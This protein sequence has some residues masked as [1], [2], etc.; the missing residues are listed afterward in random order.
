M[1][2][3]IAVQAATSHPCR[4]L[5]CQM[6]FYALPNPQQ[7][8][9]LTKLEQV[10]NDTLVEFETRGV[11]SDDLLK[12]KVS[13][14]TDAIYGLQ[15]VAGK[16][17]NLAHYQTVLGNANYTQQ[18]VARYNNVTK[19]DVMRVFKQYIKGKTLTDP[20]LHKTILSLMGINKQTSIHAP[21]S[22]TVV[23]F[24]TNNKDNFIITLDNEIFFID[25]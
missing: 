22:Y 2:S 25:P 12:T 9:S 5:S 4:E 19:A 10:I 13:I 11:N 18:Q 6:S 17:T 3:G 15:S 20:G 8:L 16:V 24:D 21:H 23:D 14:E 7:G 1:K